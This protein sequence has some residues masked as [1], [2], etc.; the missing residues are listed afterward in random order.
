VG[1]HLDD[2]IGTPDIGFFERCVS[3]PRDVD[4]AW[5]LFVKLWNREG[6]TNQA[7]QWLAQLR[8][9]APHYFRTHSGGYLQVRVDA[10]PAYEK[11]RAQFGAQ[12]SKDQLVALVTAE[13]ERLLNREEEGEAHEAALWVLYESI[14]HLQVRYWPADKVPAGRTPSDMVEQALAGH[15]LTFAL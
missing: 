2:T 8:T 6:S 15:P 5:G 10:R 4:E 11:L 12:P 1:A 14:P 13:Q 7:Q 3:A 9:L